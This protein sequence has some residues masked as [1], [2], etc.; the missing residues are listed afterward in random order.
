M[1]TATFDRGL[2][3]GV[4]RWLRLRIRP[5]RAVPLRFSQEIVVASCMALCP[6]VKWDGFKWPMI[7]DLL[8]DD[9]HYQ[10]LNYMQNRPH[11]DGHSFGPRLVGPLERTAIAMSGLQQSG[12]AAAAKALPPMI[13]FGVG[14]DRHFE[15]ALELQQRPTPFESMG[16]VDDDLIFAATGYQ[17][18]YAGTPHCFDWTHHAADRLA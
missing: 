5:A 16:V 8:V 9:G 3:S 14:E 12:A 18:R 4:S 11:W 15:L 2:T 6:E 10:W 17:I 1:D 13:P 7:E